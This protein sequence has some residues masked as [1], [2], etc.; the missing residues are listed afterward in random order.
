[1]LIT[2][3]TIILPVWPQYAE[4]VYNVAQTGHAYISL[5]MLHRYLESTQLY[6]NLMQD[7][8]NITQ[9]GQIFWNQQGSI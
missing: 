9:P 8:Y 5:L 2:L 1:M 3:H 7:I 4:H 6:I